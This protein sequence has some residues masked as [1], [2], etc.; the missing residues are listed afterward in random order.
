MIWDR[1][2]D[3]VTSMEFEEFLDLMTSRVSAKDNKSDLRKVFHLF[4]EERTGFITLQC[5]KKMVKE[6][7]ENIDEAELQE[8]IANADLDK[9]GMVSE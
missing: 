2:Q 6:M 9:D 5:L 8:M 4:D 7:G 1:L 3:G